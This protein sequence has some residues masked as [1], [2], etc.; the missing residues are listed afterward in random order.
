[1][2]DAQ[3]EQCTEKAATRTLPGGRIIA[4]NTPYCSKHA[5]EFHADRLQNDEYKYGG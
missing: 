3:W 4:M 1:M 5:S 2:G